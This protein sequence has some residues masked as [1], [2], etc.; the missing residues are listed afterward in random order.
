[1]FYNELPIVIFAEM[2]NYFCG[3]LAVFKGNSFDVCEQILDSNLL[4]ISAVR[5]ALINLNKHIFAICGRK[6]KRA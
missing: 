6:D 3:D 5:Q 4:K 1:M 2:K